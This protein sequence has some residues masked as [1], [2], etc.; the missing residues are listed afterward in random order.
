M[1]H[2]EAVAQLAVERY[3]LGELSGEARNSFEEHLFDCT[4]CAE[5]LHQSLIFTESVR[6]AL[7]PSLAVAP[8]ATPAVSHETPTR[9]AVLETPRRSPLSWLWQPWVLA[10]ALA[11]CLAVIVYQS[12]VVLPGMQRQVAE[13]RTPAVLTPLVLAN[14]SARGGDAVPQITAPRNGYYL[15]SVD[16]PPSPNAS[17]YRCTL[18]SARGSELWHIDITPG[19]ARDAVTIQVP[20]MT[21]AAGIDELRVQAIPAQGA[22]S[23]TLVPLASYKYQLSLVP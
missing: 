10:P 8:A 15:L 14:A 17:A 7:R 4:E 9:P 11:A 18:L 19:Q 1:T 22:A 21:A 12:L 16:I 5:D 6:T 3:L 2:Q 23:D 13:A 20:V